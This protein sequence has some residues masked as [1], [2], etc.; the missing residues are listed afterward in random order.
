[1]IALLLP[2]A[3]CG[4]DDSASPL[5][6]PD[7]SAEL[8]EDGGSVEHPDRNPRPPRAG[9]GGRSADAAATVEVDAGDGQGIP[10]GA[11]GS[12]PDPT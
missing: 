2:A 8:A 7:S 4:G 3:A 6:T 5:A 11:M 9:E 1:M 10:D 12:E